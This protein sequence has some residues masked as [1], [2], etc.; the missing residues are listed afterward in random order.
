MTACV[1]DRYTTGTVT[2]VA[3]NSTTMKTRLHDA[4]HEFLYS[5]ISH[6]W[7]PI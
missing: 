5:R 6:R 2:P 7:S 3:P 4:S 1:I